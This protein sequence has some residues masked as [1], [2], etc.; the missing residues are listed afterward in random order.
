MKQSIKMVKLQV[1]ST[2]LFYK[3]METKE[4]KWMGLYMF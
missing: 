4:I 3:M 1:K 2:G